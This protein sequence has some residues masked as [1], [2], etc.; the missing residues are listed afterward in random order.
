MAEQTNQTTEDLSKTIENDLSEQFSNNCKVS[1]NK[2][3]RGTGAGGANTNK[4]GLKFEEICSL[5]CTHTVVEYLKQTNMKK[6]K[7]CKS[8]AESVKFPNSDKTY[9]YLTK[10]MFKRYMNVH[11]YTSQF[12]IDNPEYEYHGT[13]E[14]D[15]CY[16]YIHKDTK[17][18]FW[19]ENKEQKGEGSVCE[20]L[21]GAKEKEKHLKDRYP[22]FTIVYIL[23]LGDILKEKCKGEIK[24]LKTNNIPVY[25]GSDKDFK[26]KIIDYIINYE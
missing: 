11:N 6:Y 15:D 10:S 3:N 12:Y 19:I 2:K 14:P 4:S 21:Q 1:K 24:G 26:T 20:K 23:I 17:I 22:Q 18:L 16:L 9:M 5:E 7:H 13:K 8:N 25:Y